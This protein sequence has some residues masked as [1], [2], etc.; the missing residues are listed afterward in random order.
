M[1]KNLHKY[2]VYD[3]LKCKKL[4]RFGIEA[5]MLS[6]SDGQTQWITKT[7]DKCGFYRNTLPDPRLE[8]NPNPTK[9]IWFGNLLSGTYRAFH[10]LTQIF[11]ANHA[12]FPIQMYAITV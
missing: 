5:K 8:K 4:F 2:F 9:M 12:T 1:W 10:K 11:T 6:V 7:Y 3:R